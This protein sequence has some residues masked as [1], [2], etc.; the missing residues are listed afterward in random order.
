MDAFLEGTL[1]FVDQAVARDEPVLVVVSEP[2]IKALSAALGVASEGV[3]FADMADVGRNPG[4]II[5]AWRDFVDSAASS[6][7]GVHGIGE[8]V[9][10]ERSPAELVECQHHESLLNVAFRSDD[11]RL[12]C[13]YDVSTLSQAIIDEAR[14]S[15][16]YLFGP[17]RS[18]PS[19]GFAGSG[20]LSEWRQAPLPE[21]PGWASILVLTGSE[22]LTRVRAF[23]ARHAV[24]AGLT[25]RRIEDVVLA[26]NEMATNSLRYG[27]GR[28]EVRLWSEGDSLLLDFSDQGHIEEPM[29]GRYRPAPDGLGGRGFWLANHLC[30]LVQIRSSE[31]GTVVRLHAYI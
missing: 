26:A 23:V 12:M 7:R 28:V 4:R 19:T 2:K 29:V 11:F 22:D 15:H 31:S 30:D 3:S 10:F 18:C 16:P 9:S 6:G 1:R 8:P 13:P 25:S 14:R 5:A 17:L 21:P 27:G 24:G 20:E